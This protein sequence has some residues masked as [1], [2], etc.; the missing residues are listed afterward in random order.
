[1]KEVINEIRKFLEE[2]GWEPTRTSVMAKSISIEAAEL[3][4]LFQWDDPTFE[5]TKPDI[6]RME[7]IKKEL[8][9]VLIYCCQMATYLDLDVEE[10]IR[11]KLAKQRTKYPV[12]KM[13][14][15]NTGY[16]EAR[17]SHRVTKSD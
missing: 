13:K 11:S 2:R 17:D 3:L 1:M 7:K 14:E 15:S 16:F 6:E 8:A 4:E 5:E 10:I 12:E 9:D